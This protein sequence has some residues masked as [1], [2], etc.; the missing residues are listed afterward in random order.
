MKIRIK[1]LLAVMLALILFTVQIYN[2]EFPADRFI[3]RASGIPE[4]VCTYQFN[5]SQGTSEV[6]VRNGDTAEGSNSGTIP[7]TDTSTTVKYA[8]GISGRGI[9]L[10]GTYGLKLYPGIDS[11]L[12]TIS[13]WIKP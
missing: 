10:D 13:L 9:Y 7:V 1:R 2:M 8:D 11:P 6:V 12:Y 5:N 4:A 3:A